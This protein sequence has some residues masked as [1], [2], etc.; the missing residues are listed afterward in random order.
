MSLITVNASIISTTA[1]LPH[2]GVRSGVNVPSIWGKAL[3]MN[4]MPSYELW[5]RIIVYICLCCAYFRTR[6]KPSCIVALALAAYVALLATIFGLVLAILVFE[7][8]LYAI[9][10]VTIYNPLNSL[11][12]RLT[13][14]I[15]HACVLEPRLRWL[16]ML[17][18]FFCV[19]P[20]CVPLLVLI[21][22]AQLLLCMLLGIGVI[23]QVLAS[24]IGIMNVC[25]YRHLDQLQFFRFSF[26]FNKS[27]RSK[28]RRRTNAANVDVDIDLDLEAGIVD[29]EP[30]EISDDGAPLTIL[31]PEPYTGD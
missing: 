27:K 22:C 16:G 18:F 21:F 15:S 19:L 26:I 17:M 12:L 28:R 13:T 30:S 2:N 8:A 14:S 9:L 1:V 20:I 31:P 5:E 29:V 6:T 24:L 25:L 11:F 3:N 10:F 23:L 4:I 7:L